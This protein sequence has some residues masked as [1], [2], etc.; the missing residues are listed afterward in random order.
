MTYGHE[1]YEEKQAGTQM[2]SLKLQLRQSEDPPCRHQDWTGRGS[3][4]PWRWNRHPLVLIPLALHSSFTGEFHG[5][6]WW[7]L[8]P[9]GFAKVRSDSSEHFQFHV[10]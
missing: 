5:Q 4:D 7:G 3:E 10:D 1:F 9:A 6:N 2:A 8:G